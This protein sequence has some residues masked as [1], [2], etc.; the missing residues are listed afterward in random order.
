MIIIKDLDNGRVQ[1]LPQCR[2]EIE[3]EEETKTAYIREPI[4]T[5]HLEEIEIMLIINGYRYKNIVI[6][7]PD[8]NRGY[9]T[10]KTLA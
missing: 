2:Y 6:G 4:K 9:E 7:D 1:I 3:W 10:I 8:V 5:H